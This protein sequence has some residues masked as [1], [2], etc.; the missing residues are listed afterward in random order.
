MP[1]TQTPRQLYLRTPAKLNLFLELVG[2]RADGFHEIETVMVAVDCYDSL[3]MQASQGPR[4]V[5]LH[6]RW[7]PSPAHWQRAIGPD[8]AQV[9][10]A[11]PD[12]ASNLVHRA[13]SRVCEM[14]GLDLAIDVQLRKRIPA[15]AGMGGGSSDAAAAIVGTAHLAGLT[16]PADR[17]RL[18][19]I[20]AEL[21][22]DV[23]FFLQN[24]I[25]QLGGHLPVAEAAIGRG[26]GELLE[27]FVLPKP[28]WFVVVYPP[29]ALST[30]AVYAQSRIPQHPASA[31]DL[32]AQLTE[33]ATDPL[34]YGFVNR[35]LEPARGIASEIDPLL[36]LLRN[37]C[38]MPAMMTGSG[39]ACFV[40][41]RDQQSALA[42][43][44]KVRQRL[45][46]GRDLGHVMVLSS[47]AASP[48]VRIYRAG[49]V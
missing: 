42:G 37:S 31:H 25:P 44:I 1:S 16:T 39:S 34:H 11:I 3:R 41:C 18:M 26:R 21:G 9:L 33:P 19:A 8:A 30:A 4:Q 2:K 24:W 13:I 36:A 28:C 49:R 17:L 14:F 48:Q 15:G 23:P 6:S 5:R 45:T 43:A 27:P 12:D 35:L 46:D 32:V 7:M 22:S 29:L 20:A 10:L 38:Q 40:I 47:T